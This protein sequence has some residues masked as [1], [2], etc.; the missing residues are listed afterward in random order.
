DIVERIR[1]EAKAGLDRYQTDREAQNIVEKT[2]IGFDFEFD[3]TEYN[4][5]GTGTL[6]FKDKKAA[7][8]PG[9][10]VD[11]TGAAERK[12]QNARRFLIVEDLSKLKDAECSGPAVRANWVYPMTGTIGMDEVVSTYIRLEKLSDLKRPKDEEF[13]EA[14]IPKGLLGSKAVLF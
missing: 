7:N 6:T 12:R 11:F 1:C 2:T 9:F 3:M 4:N 5:A 10:Q 13:K 14:H 8:L